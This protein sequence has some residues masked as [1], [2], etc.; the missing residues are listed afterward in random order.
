MFMCVTS[1]NLI[2]KCVNYYCK[3]QTYCN[4]VCFPKINKIVVVKCSY[5]NISRSTQILNKRNFI[6]D[7]V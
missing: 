6:F 4:T 1:G 5:T 3:L 7:F 2:G